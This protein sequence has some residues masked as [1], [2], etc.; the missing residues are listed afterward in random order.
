MTYQILTIDQA[1]SKLSEALNQSVSRRQVRRWIDQG[2]LIPTKLGRKRYIA[3]RTLVAFLEWLT[4]HPEP[5][6]HGKG[7]RGYFGPSYRKAA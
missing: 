5:D 2:L 7:H 1:A 4:V 6:V 3:E